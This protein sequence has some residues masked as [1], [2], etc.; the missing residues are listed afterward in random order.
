MKQAITILDKLKVEN[1][2]LRKQ[3]YENEK[4]VN[5]FDQCIDLCKRDFTYKLCLYDQASIKYAIVTIKM[6]HTECTD[7]PNH[8]DIVQFTEY[9]E[10]DVIKQL[11]HNSIGIIP[12]FK[13]TKL[14][15]NNAEY[16]SYKFQDDIHF[17]KLKIP[18]VMD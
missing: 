13:Y 7:L 8:T 3:F 9:I 12:N 1:S 11:P 17:I 5:N 10:N 18:F 2:F 4:F 6:Y 15:L 16:E 14:N